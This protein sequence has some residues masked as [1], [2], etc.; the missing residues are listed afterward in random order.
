MA[1]TKVYSAGYFYDLSYE[2]LNPNC[3]K[4]ILILHGW[5]ANKELMKQAFGNVLRDFKQVYLDLPGFGNSSIS[6]AMDS[7]AYV[8][9]IEDFLEHLELKIDYLMGHSFGGKIATLLCQ[10][11]SF[12]GL[13]LLSSAGIVLPKSFR[14]KF[15]IALFKMIKKLPFANHLREFFIS[16]DAKGMSETMYETFK[17]VVNENIEEYFKKIQSPI[18]IFWGNEDKATPLK[19][20]AIIHSLA[21]KGKFFSLDGDHF[22]FLKHALFIDNKIKEEFLK[23]D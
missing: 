1:K 18:L 15:K 3:E 8:R 19:S 21:Q 22:F 5:G 20:G 12:K 17:K 16:K 14:V 2:I 13:I 10:R 11:K 23:N 7:F 6:V 9:V 4:T